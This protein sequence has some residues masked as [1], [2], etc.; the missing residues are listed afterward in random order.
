MALAILLSCLAVI[1]TARVVYFIVG[2]IREHRRWNNTS[3]YPTVSVVVPARNE[4][5]NL[6]RCVEALMTTDY[7]P[8]RIEYIFVNDRSTD[9]TAECLNR[10]ALQYPIR[11][12]HKEVDDN[13]PNLRGKPGALQY[14]IDNAGGEI[15]LMTD[16][17]CRVS[18]GW[19]R[20]MV[21]QFSSPDVGL[22]SG[23]TGVEGS[24]L[25]QQAQMVEWLY[26]QSMAAGAVGNGTA[27]GCFGNNMAMRRNIFTD[28]GG[29]RSIAFSLTEDMALQKAVKN[30]GYQL[31]FAIAPS[32]SVLTLPCS[33]FMEYV[34]QRHRWVRGGT[35]LGMKAVL[36]VATSIALWA[37]VAISA[38][39]EMWI[40]LWCFLF[41]RLIADSSLVYVASSLT[42]HRVSPFVIIPSMLFLVLTEL[43]LPVLV[44]KKKVTWKNQVFRM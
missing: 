18:A 44:L 10:L 35:A 39:F 2:F 17:D 6:L 4:D 36:F 41:L 29:Y 25:L 14:G 23:I 38:V 15:V 37:G 34:K 43:F 28:L 8:D 20:G 21:A 30:A 3:T 40:L 16:A 26:T 32:A 9:K 5:K 19:V 42:K 27:L 1:Y 22:V 33:H 7:P 12:V 13:N 24:R 11:V 31:R